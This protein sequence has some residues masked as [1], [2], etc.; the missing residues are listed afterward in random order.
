[1]RVVGY[2]YPLFPLELVRACGFEPKRVQAHA[3]T[4]RAAP[5]GVCPYAQACTNGAASDPAMSGIVAC[6]PCDQMRRAAETMA[7]VSYAPVFTLRTPVTCKSDVAVR[8][9]TARLHDLVTFLKQIGGHEPDWESRT[10]I[11]VCPPHVRTDKNVCRTKHRIGIVGGPLRAHDEDL[12]V[13]IREQGGEVVLDWTP[14][15]G[16]QPLADAEP[17]R[18]LDE[19]AESF[20]ATVCH[21]FQRPN[22]SFFSHLRSEAADQHLDGLIVRTYV[23]CDTWR[24]EVSRIRA[25]AGVPVLHI[26]AGDTTG[27]DAQTRTR[28]TAFVETLE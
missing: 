6:A 26:E 19:L 18:N 7:R 3:A 2:T 11:R 1:M 8:T 20:L 5:E 10:G 17:S 12:L 14:A 21:P 24:A 28:L 22:S 4:G 13:A 16:S 15:G 9:L 23:W 25:A 27:L